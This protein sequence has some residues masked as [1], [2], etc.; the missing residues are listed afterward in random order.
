MDG[1]LGAR[2]HGDPVVGQDP[3]RSF[4]WHRS[5]AVLNMILSFRLRISP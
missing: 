2:G 1:P 3:R 4:D 5:Q